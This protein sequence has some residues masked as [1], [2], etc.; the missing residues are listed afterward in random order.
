[1]NE[2]KMNVR[3]NENAIPTG[4]R[5][6]KSCNAQK[7]KLGINKQSAWILKLTLSV[8]TPYLYYDTTSFL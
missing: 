1:M 2:M 5:Y 4:I 3:C 8:L 6:N 7:K